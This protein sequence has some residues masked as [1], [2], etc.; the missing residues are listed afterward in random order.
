MLYLCSNSESRATLLKT[1]GIEFEQR[2][3]AFN[4][5]LLTT[6]NPYHFALQASQG[7]CDV[8]KRTFGLEVALLCADSVVV[9]GDGQLIRKAKSKEEARALLLAQSGSRISIV[10]AVALKTDRLY[11]TSLDATHYHFAP[12]EREDL[13]VYLE[14]GEWQGKAGACMVEGFCKKYIKDVI[15][16]ESTARGLQVEILLP[17][18]KI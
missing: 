1:F 16:Y 8:A 4:E 9:G 13:E 7:K 10:S 5:E 3:V 18:L 6:Q 17:W 12:F 11:F 15:G 2:P 14:S